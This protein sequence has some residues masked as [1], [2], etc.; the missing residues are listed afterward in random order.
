[1]MLPEFS[2]H[3]GELVK[4]LCGIV[5]NI[6]VLNHILI[7]EF[8]VLIVILSEQFRFVYNHFSKV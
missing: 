7:E 8:R 3:D 2:L 6:H 4:V 5:I 1:M